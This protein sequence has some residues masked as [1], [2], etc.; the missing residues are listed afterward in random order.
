L[1]REA[2]EEHLPALKRLIHAR[3]KARPLDPR[4]ETKLFFAEWELK[5]KANAGKNAKTFADLWGICK[6]DD[7][8]E[9]EID[10]VLYRTPDKVIKI[11]E[12]RDD[13]N[14]NSAAG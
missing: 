1:I 8:S 7:I 10:A 14:E 5:K 11:L 9:E 3:L 6:G 12:D 13:P 4:E 2:P